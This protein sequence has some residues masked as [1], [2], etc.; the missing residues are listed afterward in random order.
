MVHPWGGSH[1]QV[2]RKQQQHSKGVEVLPGYNFTTQHIYL[3]VNIFILLKL[4]IK[5]ICNSWAPRGD[6][7]RQLV[8]LGWG[9]DQFFWDLDSSRSCFLLKVCIMRCHYTK[10]PTQS[11][12]GC[13]NCR[14]TFCANPLACLVPLYSAVSRLQLV[15]P[16]YKE[17]ESTEDPPCI[18]IKTGTTWTQV[19]DTY[20]ACCDI[21]S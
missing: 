2:S 12:S 14:F 3:I 13:P 10:A 9:D 4:Y 8:K 17:G 6:S 21:W 19:G 5:S 20:P 7:S 16:E 1:S 15:L 11:L 18:Q